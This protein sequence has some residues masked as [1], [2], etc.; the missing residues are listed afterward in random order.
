MA[1]TIA[2]EQLHKI[3]TA[4]GSGLILGVFLVTFDAS[5]PTGGEE[6]DLSGYMKQV[7]DMKVQA[8][9][10]SPGYVFDVDDANFA[11]AKPKI[12]AYWSAENTHSVTQPDDHAAHAHDLVYKA[13]P[14]ANAVTMA[15][16]SLHNASAGDLT[17]AGGGAD[18][19]IQNMAA[20]KHANAAVAKHNAAALAEVTNATDLSAVKVRC[21]VWGIG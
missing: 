1:V 17:V 12:E 9:E 18:G 3:P 6:V 21:I 14:A 8:T 10:D 2:K 4:G 11:T 13:N 16:N 15:A 7:L 5:Y 19:G 20:M